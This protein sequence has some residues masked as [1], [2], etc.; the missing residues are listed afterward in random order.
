MKND[1]KKREKK[2]RE[3]KTVKELQVNSDDKIENYKTPFHTIKIFYASQ[4][5]AGK[6]D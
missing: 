4:I 6:V 5:G 2:Q 3:K 1:K